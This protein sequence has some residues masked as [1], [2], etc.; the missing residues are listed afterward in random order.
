MVIKF[1]K[2]RE[3]PRHRLLI[4]LPQVTA[5]DGSIS[6]GECW[7]CPSYCGQT[8]TRR[9]RHIKMASGCHACHHDA[10][11]VNCGKFNAGEKFVCQASISTVP[12][13]AFFYTAEAVAHVRFLRAARVRAAA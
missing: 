7:H 2:S 12:P 3:L 9:G 11:R 8:I 6:E 4:V 10:R 13:T 1:T 5:G